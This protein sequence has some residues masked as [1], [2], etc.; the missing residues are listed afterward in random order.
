M[1][2]NDEL[3]LLGVLGGEHEPQRVL[4][5]E[6][7]Q[8]VQLHLWVLHVWMYQGQH[9]HSK[10]EKILGMVKVDICM[11]IVTF[12]HKFLHFSHCIECFQNS[13]NS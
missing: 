3:E 1:G 8:L 10:V 13:E 7:R 11:A 12:K 4:E 5:V 6:Q 2:L 9:H